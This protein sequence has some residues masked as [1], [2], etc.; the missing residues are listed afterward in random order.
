MKLLVGV[1]LLCALSGSCHGAVGSVDPT[2]WSTIAADF[3]NG[4]RQSP[5][6]INSAT[7][8]QD[9]NLMSFNFTNFDDKSALT[10]IKNTG[11][12]VQ[13]AVENAKVSGGGLSTTYDILQF[14]LHWGNGS[15]VPGSEHTINGQ[16]YPMELHIVTLKESF[17]GN[18]TLALQ[19]PE[20]LAALGFLIEAVDE[21]DSPDSWNTLT[22]YLGNITLR[23][24]YVNITHQISMDDILMGVDRDKYYR[25]L[26]SLTTPTCNEVVVWTVFKDTIKVSRNLIDLFSTKI[27]V[28]N[29]TSILMTQT[30][31]PIQP[32]LRV[33]ATM[34]S[35]MDSTSSTTNSG[36]ISLAT[37]QMGIAA[38]WA[39][40]GF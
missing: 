6:N 15:R 9:A 32:N 29:A 26:G 2:T 10:K 7:V 28:G 36:T 8:T 27:R 22:S 35:T 11:R 18:V 17:N 40:K 13:V 25:Y 30:F 12:T 39:L 33:R 23:D 38:I 21:A 4:S 1:L 24:E 34:D 14:H 20:G 37:A 5:V 3:C 19:D 16:R 31:R